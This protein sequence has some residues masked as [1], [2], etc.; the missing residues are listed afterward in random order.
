MGVLVSGEKRMG[1]LVSMSP[2]YTASEFSPAFVGQCTG[3]IGRVGVT[4]IAPDGTATTAQA[5]FP[6]LQ[7]Q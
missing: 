5:I 6:C 7:D 3:R 2:A 1:V 4:V